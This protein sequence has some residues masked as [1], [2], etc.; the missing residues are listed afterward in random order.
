MHSLLL[1]ADNDEEC[2]VRKEKESSKWRHIKLQKCA[3]MYWDVGTYGERE[4]EMWGGGD[5]HKKMKT[6]KGILG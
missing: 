5:F 1:D 2:Y 4:R 3:S 6:N